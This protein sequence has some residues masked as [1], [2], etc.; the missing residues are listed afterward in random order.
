MEGMQVKKL[1]LICNAHLDP[2]WLWQWEEGAAE[3]VSTF[4]V[5]ADFCENYEGFVFN[6]NEVILYKWVEEYEPE[7]FK[8]IQRLVADGKWHIMGGWYLQPDCNMPSGESFVRQILTGR[9]YFKEKFNVVPTTAINFDSFGHNRGLVQ[10]MKK[11]GYDS[12]IFTQP[13]KDECPLPA[14]DIK[15]I[16]FDGSEIYGHRGYAGYVSLHGEAHNKVTNWINENQNKP[17]GLV[18]WGIGNHGGGPSR[19]DLEN[20]KKLMDDNKNFNI[21]HSIP[22]AYFEDIKK[23]DKDIPRWYRDFNPCYTGCYTSQIRI[24][25]KHRKLENELYMMEKM[26]SSAALQELLPYPVIE[27]NE[28]VN[29]LMMSEFHDILPGS[30]IQAVE[31]DALRFMDHGL[32]IVSKL[33]TRAF[34]ALAKGQPKAKDGDIPILV[35]NPHP[36]KVKGIFECEFQLADQNW[37]EEFSLPLVYKDGKRLPSQAE[38]EFSN[39]NLDWRKHV[40]FCAELEPSQMNRFDCQIEVLPKKPEPELKEAD[41]KLSFKTDELEIEINCNTGLVDKYAANGFNYIK[42]NAFVP[43]VIDDTDDSW[44]TLDISYNKV[45]GQFKLMTKEE[46]AKFSGVRRNTLDSVRVVEDGDVRTV[47]EAVFKYGDSFICQTYK[48]PKQGTEIQVQLR[49]Y[50]NEK[51]KMLKLSVPTVLED[52]KY[53]GQA[54]YGTQPL[55]DNGNECVAQKWVDVVSE[56]QNKSFTC[57]N[58]GTYG[59]D[60]KDGELRLTLMRSPG[61]SALTLGERSIMKEDR[62]S[63]RIDQGERLFNFWF[64]AGDVKERTE[65]VDTESIV[66]NEKPFVLSFFPSGMGDMTKPLVKL[67]DD[68]IQMTTFKK[69]E[70]SDDFIL[71]L[72]EPTGKSR[73][74]EIEFPISGIKQKVKLDK[75]EIKTFRF[76]NKDKLLKEVNLMEL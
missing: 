43:V 41:G 44:G 28:V 17:E 65:K 74:T 14:E 11:S 54:A 68:I 8:R 29:D 26:M 12:Y 46:S 69:A 55:P 47:I 30:S 63:P 42:N 49:V 20:L 2:M 64:N 34:F 58:E 31:E 76:N 9:N 10:I 16:G 56:S 39:L 13:S 66:H 51:G 72:F 75:F 70:D 59:S 25:Q 53:Y 27:I 1:H 23:R 7:L 24:K 38:R 4:R 37:K 18:L 73:S 36:F 61:Y 67:S 35:Y 60:C 71:R 48:L 45:D 5:A 22:E 21:Q 62:F 19:I 6:H 32:E 33:K 15:W 57:I 3:A 52:S 50:W 40:V